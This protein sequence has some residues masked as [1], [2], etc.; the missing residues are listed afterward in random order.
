M[1]II[2]EISFHIFYETINKMDFLIILLIIISLS[3]I[4][5]QNNIEKY[6]LEVNFI[7]P[8]HLLMVEGIFGILLSIIYSFIDDPIENLVDFYHKNK[9]INFINL[10]I[11]L[12]FFILLS[13]GEMVTKF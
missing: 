13:G 12:S 10:V 11:G 5:F 8:F 3:F 7:N 2:V 4:G 9:K 1:I 6:L